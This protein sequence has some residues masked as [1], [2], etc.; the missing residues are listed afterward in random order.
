MLRDRPCLRTK[1]VDHSSRWLLRARAA[2]LGFGNQLPD[3]KAS[4]QPVRALGKRRLA[5]LCE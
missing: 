1:V 5:N 2:D 4:Q 3:L